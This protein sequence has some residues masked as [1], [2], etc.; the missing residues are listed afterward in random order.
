M[1]FSLPIAI[2][3]DFVFGINTAEFSEIRRRANYNHVT[4]EV[5]GQS[6]KYQFLGKGEDEITLP[7]VIYP[8]ICGAMSQLSLTYVRKLAAEGEPLDFITTNITA[9]AGDVHGRWVITSVEETQSVFLGAIP[10]KIEF[11]IT[12]KRYDDEAELVSM[13]T[14]A[15]SA[16]L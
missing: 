7:G 10:Q 16:Y 6:P 15:I 11:S 8:E 13:V 14:E 2:L 4:N 9:F 5:I 1:I 12:M 3:G